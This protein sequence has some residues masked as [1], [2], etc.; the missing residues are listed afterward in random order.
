MQEYAIVNADNR[1]LSSYEYR[2]YLINNADRLIAEQQANIKA[3]SEC[4]GCTNYDQSQPPAQRTQAC[5]GN[6]CAISAPSDDG[7]GLMRGEAPSSE[8]LPLFS[9]NSAEAVQ[10]AP[11]A[12]TG[13][14]LQPYTPY[15]KGN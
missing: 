11:S 15:E 7:I 8:P 9:R 6:S 4:S 3:K 5:D 13:E 12:H 2:Q 14:Y 1:P 10:F